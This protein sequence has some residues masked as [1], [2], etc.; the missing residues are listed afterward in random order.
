MFQEE[1]FETPKT[2]CEHTKVVII[3]LN[4]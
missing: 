3:D 4:Q 2:P 1:K